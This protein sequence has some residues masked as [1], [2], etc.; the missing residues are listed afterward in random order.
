MSVAGTNTGRGR[1][2]GQ[3]PLR[4]GG[5]RSSTAGA[6]LIAMA[7]VASGLAVGTTSATAAPIAA[8]R[9]LGGTA[10]QGPSP[11]FDLA[12]KKVVTSPA[13]PA[14]VSPGDN[15]TYTITVT[16]QGGIDATN[17]SIS[18]DIPTGWTLNDA[19]WLASASGRQ[20]TTTIASIPAG[21]SV[22]VT[23][24]ATVGAVAPIPNSANPTT[25]GTITGIIYQDYNANGVI[26]STGAAANPAIDTPVAGAYVTAT[27]VANLGAD[28]TVGTADDLYATPVTTGPTT[29][30]GAY[31]LNVT[32]SPCRVEFVQAAGFESSAQG[33]DNGSAVQFVNAGAA[34]VNFLVEWPSEYCQNNPQLVLPCFAQGTNTSINVL[35]YFDY[36]LQ[37]PDA[38]V[39]AASA[40][41]SVYGIATRY[42]KNV[43]AG[44]YVKRGADYGA[45][46]NKNV[47]FANFNKASTASVFATLPGTLTAHDAQQSFSIDAPVF[48][49]VGREG[50]ADLEMSEDG[51]TLYAINL[52]DNKL[53][54]IPVNGSGAT[55][56]AG[57]PTAFSIPT[58]AAH[59]PGCPVPTD[60]HPFGLG[61]HRGLI[62]VGVVCGADSTVTGALPTGDV[63]KLSADVIT[64]NPSNGTFGASPMFTVPLNY[65]RGCAFAKL[66]TPACVASNPVTSALTAEWEAWGARHP[67]GSS[68][69]HVVTRP[70]PMLSDIQFVK[71]DLVLAFRATNRIHC[72]FGSA[73]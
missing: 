66:D 2:D 11:V 7:V 24:M 23:I 48:D 10:V 31:T 57:T 71:G 65:T 41:G 34:G 67:A 73:P 14:T 64:F 39:V 26:N 45:Q 27:C 62:Y 29:A 1:L 56:S 46:G 70:Q 36:A 3:S 52:S 58:D 15:V 17:V 32:G 12:L 69:N 19:T 4:R 20:A 47:I 53:Y 8:T 59:V 40:M 16:N 28:N 61:V 51:N 13:P 60:V 38:K 49:R 54:S 42:D 35:S 18:D 43:F 50:L 9:S 6:V 68:P 25:G 63:T 44:R 33:T 72:C 22:S 21:Q 5:G 37:V 30:S 55:A